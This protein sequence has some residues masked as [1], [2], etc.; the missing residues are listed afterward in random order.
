VLA[1]GADIDACDGYGQ[2]ALML[3]AREGHAKV[4]EWLVEHGAALDHTAKYG[5]SALMLAV[6]AGR[7]DVVRILAAAGANLCLRGTGA[8]GFTA[9][10]AL[11][12]AIARGDPD[13]VEMPRTRAA[14]RP[15]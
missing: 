4:V 7:T 1:S 8:P 11:D 13:M 10:T 12:L 9:K 5:L 3:A 2:T 6:I 14:G 15:K